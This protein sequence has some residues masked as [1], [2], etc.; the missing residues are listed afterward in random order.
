MRIIRTNSIILITAL[1]SLL[2]MLI[3]PREI[4]SMANISPMTQLPEA[5]TPDERI[6]TELV[7]I[8][9]GRDAGSY[10]MRDLMASEITE[11]TIEAYDLIPGTDSHI[12]LREDATPE[13]PYDNLSQVW[14]MLSSVPADASRLI[15]EIRASDTENVDLY[16]GFDSN[17]NQKPDPEEEI[18][19]G[20]SSSWSEYCNVEF[21]Q[22]GNWWVLVQ[23]WNDFGGDVIDSILLTTA[24]V[25]DKDEGNMTFDAPQSVPAL[26]PF[27]LRIKFD[28]ANA[29]EGQA[30]YGSFSLGTDS[31]NPG[32]V[33]RVEVNLN[34]IGDDVEKRANITLVSMGDT[35]TYTITVNPNILDEEVVYNIIDLIPNGLTYVADSAHATAGDVNV[36][37]N[38][39]TWLGALSNPNQLQPSYQVSTSANDETCDTGFGGYLNLEDQDIFVQEPIQGNGKAFSFFSTGDPI[40]FFGQQYTGMHITDDGFVVFDLD[41]N[42]T[43][44]VENPQFIPDLDKPSNIAAMLWNDM[45]IV[46]DKDLN[47]G[48]SAATVGSNVMIV[49]YDNVRKI[50]NATDYYD[51]EIVMTRTVDNSHGSYEIVFAYENLNGSLV[52]PFTIGVENAAG[53]NA[54]VFINRAS[55]EN[56]ISD[57]F[58][59]C[60]DAV[61]PVTAPVIINYQ[62]KVANDLESGTILIN[63]A[64]STTSSIGSK[65]ETAVAPVI[66]SYKSF[67][68]IN[69]AFN[70][71]D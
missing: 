51:I 52:G 32:N 49:E 47:H 56:I 12:L 27:D 42:Y 22:E 65:K 48:V 2:V 28:L 9:T 35:I 19:S 17:G 14:W 41:V 6:P 15:Y 4:G 46:Y 57:G 44:S 33:L 60:F 30:W 69:F 5:I 54:E 50:D 36:S 71:S 62:A 66:I 63:R 16:V 37:G 31:S 8:T 67:F 59:I 53:D 39:L 7:S 20:I 10:L 18:C 13:N 55:A 34:R 23:D 29:N 24:V 68:P 38:V 45:K 40:T 43:G 21:P 64:D 25:A 61:Q 26:E 3:I 70:K 58:M 1:V 11:M